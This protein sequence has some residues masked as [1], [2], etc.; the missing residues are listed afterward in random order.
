MTRDPREV[1]GSVIPEVKLSEV[2]P[3]SRE[4]KVMRIAARVTARGIRDTLAGIGR[5]VMADKIDSPV[6]VKIEL[7]DT[8]KTDRRD[9]ETPSVS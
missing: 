5:L 1:R 6:T 9:T 8:G 7:R 2:N 3:S 4:V